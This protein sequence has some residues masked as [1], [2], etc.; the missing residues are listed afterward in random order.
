PVMPKFSDYA[1]EW[2]E[3]YAKVNCKTGTYNLDAQIIRDHLNP[4]FGKKKLDEI[5]KNMIEAFIAKKIGE[6]KAKAT[7]R[8]YMATLR[9]IL[10]GA[11]ERGLLTVNGAS[12]MGRFPKETSTKATAKNIKP[13]T[14]AELQILFAKAKE[15]DFVLYAFFLTM[16]RLSEMIGLQCGD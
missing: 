15:K 14:P 10:S 9:R 7:V 8:N 5:T 12:N 6:K 4:E 2:L 1:K 3:L 11:V 16:V 13:L